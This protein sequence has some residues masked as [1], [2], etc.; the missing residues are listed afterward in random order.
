[1]ASKNIACKI[2]SVCALFVE[3][4]LSVLAYFACSQFRLAIGSR[5]LAFLSPG[6]RLRPE[7][8]GTQQL[9]VSARNA[10]G[11]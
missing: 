8:P 4:P 10:P 7:F 1:M 2:N 5:I 6:F 3:T 11:D 9:Q